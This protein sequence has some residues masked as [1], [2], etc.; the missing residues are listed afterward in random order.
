MNELDKANQCQ[1]PCHNQDGII[2]FDACCEGRCEGCEQFFHAL[3]HH[4]AV[5]S[6][7][8]VWRTKQKRAELRRLD[9]MEDFHLTNHFEEHDG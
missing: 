9:L 2:H 7:W 6:E 1:C 8:L 5:C 3:N 4:R